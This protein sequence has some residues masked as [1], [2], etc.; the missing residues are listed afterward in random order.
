MLK[1]ATQAQL[2][3][4]Q[5]EGGIRQS[6]ADRQYQAGLNNEKAQQDIN[7]AN[8]ERQLGFDVDQTAKARGAQERG[9]GYKQKTRADYN[10]NK[11]NIWKEEM[12]DWGGRR[13]AA[14]M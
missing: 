5:M 3:Y 14:E 11:Q 9:L 8:I 2:G 6:D 7:R 4:S 13:T 10:Q 12:A 1:G